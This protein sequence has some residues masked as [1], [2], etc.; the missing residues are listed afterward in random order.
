MIGSC[1]NYLLGKLCALFSHITICRSRK[2]KKS[3][4]VMTKTNNE[5][6]SIA[7]HHGVNAE[8]QLYRLKRGTKLRLVPA[9]NLLG[10]SVALYCNYPVTGSDTDEKAEFIRNQYLHLNWYS[11]DGKKLSDGLHPYTQITDLNTHCELELNRS[12]TFHFYFIYDTNNERKKHQGSLYIQVEP[13]ITVGTQKSSKDIP[14]DSIRC[15]TVLSKCL[16]PLSTWEKK[17][18]VAKNSGYNMIHFTPIQELGDSKS[19]Y[20]LKN[21]LKP[22]PDFND[23]PINGKLNKNATFEA[24][25]KVIKKMRTEWGVTSICDIVLNH[26]ANES[27]W[28]HE[29]PDATYSCLTMPH[30]RPAFLLDV[31]FGWVTRDVCAGSLE[32]V[33]V[34]PLVETEDHIQSLRHHIHTTYLSKANLPQFYQCNIEKYVQLFSEKIRTGKPPT[35]SN[36]VHEEELVL[37]Q[38]LEY[39]R[40]G[41]TID[42]DYA[43]AKYNVFR[44][45]SFDEDTR[46]RKCIEAFRS[47][48]EQLNEDV[49]QEI[50]GFLDYG[51]ENALA[52]VRYERVQGDGPRVRVND[53]SH[54]LFSRYFT[55]DEKNLTFDEYE[56]LIY[57]DKGK[58]F[59][60]HNG[61]VMSA[62][63]L[64]DFALPQ[65]GR[66]NV[67]IKRELIAWG[68]SVK[69][70]FGERPEDS[71]Y[72]WN[73]MRKYVETTARI[74]DGVRL[75]NCHSTP[76]HVAEYML[77]CARRI[78]P[79]L[80]VAAEL[81]TNSD[82][83]DNIFVNRLGIT[84]LIREA[85]SAW[86]SHEEGRLVYRYGG[87]PVG[88]FYNN[89]KRPLASGIAHALFLDLTHDNPS[90]IEKRSVFDLLP[91]AALV[92]MACCATGSNRGYD[93]LVP[94]HIHVVNEE[95]QYQEWENGVDFKSGIIAAK[96]ALNHLHGELAEAGFSQ[97]FVDQ[98]HPDIVAV[99]RHNPITHQSVILVAHTAFSKPH[100]NAGPTG[101]RP[102]VFE[103]LL[104]E[105]ILEAEL[106]H[107][108][109][110][111]LYDQFSNF[112]K[113]KKYI[114][115]LD[116]YE[117]NISEH[118]PLTESNIFDHKTYKDGNRT[119]L[120]FLNLRPGSV[121]A[122]K[123]SLYK[124]TKPQLD[125]VD[126]L[127][128]S[129]QN[130]TGPKYDELK[131]IIS[132]LDLND[133]NRAI[134]RCDQEERDMGMG[135]GSY[136][137][138]D[139]GPLVYCGTQGFVS[140]LTEI[141][142]NNDLGHPF[143]NNLRQ[144]NW[145]ID[146]IHERLAKHP[147]TVNLSKWFADNTEALKQ[148]PRYLIPS[149][150]D[151]IVTG[152]HQL[153][154]DHAIQL[155][156]PFI[157]N[158]SGFVKDLALGS[159]QCV[160][161]SNSADLPKLSPKVSEPKP[162]S[163]CPTLSAGLPHFSTG[164]MRCWG[165]DT[166]IALRGLLLLTG[167]YDEA[168]YIILGFA[169]CLRHGLIPNLLD[170]GTKP[171]FNCRD[172]IWWWLYSIKDYVYEAPKGH[173]ILNEPVS[174]LF[175]TDD[176]DAK[177]AGECDQPLHQ[178]IQEALNIH[179]QGLVFRERNAGPDIDAHMKDQGFN[180]QIG[181]NP[182]TGFVFGGNEANCGT[183]MDKMGSSDKAGNRG[184]P[185][186]PRDGS[187]V[188]IVGL[189]YAGLRFLQKLAESQLIPYDSV[190]RNGKNGDKTA[191][192]FKKWADLVQAN[193]ENEFYTTPEMGSLV[194]K[195][196]IYKDSVGASQAWADYQLRCN[197]PITM[198]AAP[199]LFDPKHAW[200]A[201]EMAKKYLLGPLGMKTLDPED[202]GYRGNYD[203]SNDSDDAK[204]AHGANYHQGPEWVWPIGFYLR[205]RLIFAEK[206]NCLK[207]TIA[208][209]YSILMTHLREIE[210]SHWRGLAELTNENGSY[211]SDSCRTQ[212][213]SMATV[214]EVLND[215]NKFQ[216]AS[217]NNK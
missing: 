4:Q 212:A 106:T 99:T 114:N 28:I 36:A 83:T 206:N 146:Y 56:K 65:T 178:V 51:V 93:E 108:G 202:W 166:F 115:G 41:T 177:P 97:V 3:I 145:M 110:G 72:L 187:A 30:L 33:G 143:C 182:N 144:G 84:S 169:A 42:F 125:Q 80:Y 209:T 27:E 58:Q 173:A 176:S 117:L 129:F 12:G 92:S 32:N 20:S 120:N 152:V 26:T 136:D 91:S 168:R 150:F 7:L 140:V 195:V 159:V 102:L 175:P 77:D 86:D 208:E 133:L 18:I 147:N 113:N 165:R 50:Q 95:R 8:G 141:T 148:I 112:V 186:T 197:F 96:R 137:I 164:Y 89:L 163:R 109:S 52:G 104:D 24:I 162:S 121:V 85:M 216:V 153:L 48:L 156:S 149:Y 46:R 160:A 9:P 128:K 100:P 200:N 62:D 73:H 131:Q 79:E 191:W 98:M 201:L 2:R 172:A 119:Q 196:G 203:N 170:N 74:F 174:R 138:P 55:P 54:P 210:T 60:A 68:D 94:H 134:Y 183:W 69:L 207:E 88:A 23:V 155:M 158:G 53:N 185:S 11:R 5:V 179:F 127:I 57:T 76:L 87:A 193:F 190:E 70:R 90:P 130:E 101:V 22:N 161:I 124:E 59:M 61:W 180:N 13:K 71:P 29:H 204:V 45:D 214:L 184:I 135:S 111:K 213:W 116:E 118:I 67:Y 205:A 107:N 19:A 126:E 35:A 139:Y 82:H 40:L 81:F 25:E 31:V 16:G 199:D 34:P 217:K 21:Q 154:V 198:V 39:K 167:R 63:P 188:E 211:C 215:L 38:D 103:G 14:L 181:T 132:K 15:Q 194:N 47:K 43:L 151:I 78:N 123:V 75:D 192:T 157:R 66:G 49:R 142:P 189:Q 122:V 171:R 44:S 1:L 17:L 6:L 37:I 105:I 64:N 10:R